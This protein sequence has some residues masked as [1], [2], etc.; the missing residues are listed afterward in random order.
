MCSICPFRENGD[1]SKNYTE[2][3]SYVCLKY[4]N[5]IRPI[6]G[7]EPICTGHRKWLKDKLKIR[8]ANLSKGIVYVS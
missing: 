3:K 1:F 2:E 5:S 7:N 4:E 6:D 8:E